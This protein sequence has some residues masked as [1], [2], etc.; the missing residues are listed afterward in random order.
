MP[1]LRCNKSFAFTCFRELKGIYVLQQFCSPSMYCNAFYDFRNTHKKKKFPDNQCNYFII[2]Y[3]LLYLQI[4]RRI[5]SLKNYFPK[6]SE[7]VPVSTSFK[8]FLNLFV[9]LSSYFSLFWLHLL[10]FNSHFI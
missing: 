5:D 1:D 9:N 6:R 3:Y 4:N 2:E 10:F 7:W 8:C